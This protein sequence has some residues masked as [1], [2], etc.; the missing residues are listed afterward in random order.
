[1]A[2]AIRNLNKNDIRTAF[3]CGHELLN[4][5]LN[6]QVNQDIKRSLTACFVLVNAEQQV[7]GYYTLSSNSIPKETLPPALNKKLPPT[8]SD[9]PCV[10]L[11]RLAVDNSTKGMGYGEMLLMDALHRCL[12]HSQSLGI[13]A[14]VTDPI[15]QQAISF[16]QRYGF[17]LLPGSGKMFLPMKT[18][19]GEM[20]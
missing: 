12:L 11:G 1:M 7:L 9:I 18:I 5:Y 17:I 6:K 14:V 10:L 4:K 3:D 20:A 15:D 8:Y 13:M 16:Y 2:L 19:L